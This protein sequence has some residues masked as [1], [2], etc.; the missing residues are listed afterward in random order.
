[1][2][3]SDPPQPPFLLIA[4][5]FL[6]GREESLMMHKESPPAKNSF[7]EDLDR[8]DVSLFSQIKIFKRTVVSVMHILT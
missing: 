6:V 5:M 1:M 7:L 8:L 4:K 3:I 2:N